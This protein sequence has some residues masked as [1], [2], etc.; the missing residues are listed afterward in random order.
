MN[1]LSGGAGDNYVDM[2]EENIAKGDPLVCIKAI[3]R[4]PCLCTLL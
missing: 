1:L 4:L 3:T 2:T